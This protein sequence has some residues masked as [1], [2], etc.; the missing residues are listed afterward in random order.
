M[1]PATDYPLGRLPSVDARD[2]A[3]PMAAAGLPAAPPKR[4]KLSWTAGPLRDQSDASHRAA[5]ARNSC[6]GQS[7]QGLLEAT[8]V[9]RMDG[10]SA[11]AIYR[12]A[13]MH[14]QWPGNDG[15]DRGTS[16]RAAMEYL[17]Q[18]GLIGSYVWAQSVLDVANWLLRRGPV[19]CGTY[20]LD[21]M[22]EPEPDGRVRPVGA[23]KGGHAY[24]ATGVDLTVSPQRF[25]F[26]QRWGDWGPHRGDFWIAYED[27]ESLF[28]MNGEAVT[29]V[30]RKLQV[31]RGAGMLT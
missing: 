31:H 3:Y 27:F 10:P 15:E 9:P 30:E 29:A 1:N 4:R 28:A 19:V 2:A 6:V 14:D 25:K 12:W 5:R 13:V 7:C 16:I 22:Y 26:R 23:V 17:L 18:E 21:G 20:W 8:P 24:L 11:I